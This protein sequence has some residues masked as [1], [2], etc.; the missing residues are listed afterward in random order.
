M[1]HLFSLTYLLP[2]PILVVILTQI[3][4]FISSRRQHLPLPPGPKPWP[5]LGNILQVDKKLHICIANF[6]KV[7]GP[8]ISLRLGNQVL[9]VASTPSSAAEVLKNHDRL[10]SARFILKAIPSESHIL[11]RVAIVWNPAC[12]DHWK[13]LRALCRTELFSPKAIESQAILREKKLAEMLEFLITKQGQAVN[14]AE[15]VFGTIFNTIS[16]L[17]FSTDLIGFENQI[18]GVKSLLWSM[19]EMA[20][21]PNI[22][23]FYPILAPL[24]PQGLKRKMTKCLKEMFGVWE[25][26]IKER[27]RTHDHDHAAPK[28]DFLDIFLSNG[29]DDDQI[30]WLV[31]ELLSAG[32][33]TT[34]TSVEWA[35]A[36]L[37]KNKEAMKKVREELDREI[38]KN[39]IK[40][41]HVS[42][43]P[44]LNACVK[45]TLRLH[46]PA[47]FLIPRRATENC[48]VMNYTIP[49]DSQV[50]VNVWAIGRD[51]SVWEDPSSFKPERFLGSSL[52]VKGHD[53]ELIPFGSGRRICPGLPMATRQLSLVLAS[54]IHCFDWSLPNGGDPAKVDMTEKFGITLQMEHP[55][56]IIP[57][58]KLL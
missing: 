53:F 6:A 16:H 55:L 30:N 11:E 33:D 45:E 29:F 54:L 8:L 38:N 9:V 24:D 51:P 48:E 13:S 7:Y 27:R 12:N 3:I 10:L 4:S 28:T 43:L 15:V 23:E 41:S 47:P 56:L 32:T 40:E 18:G 50:L 20:T 17:L 42:Q 2:L 19:M 22:A 14:V 1:L 5:I 58:P 52:D 57:K 49:K 26:Y 37:L 31:M 21:S 44:Y 25:I 46:P 36:E 35:M 39:P 34:S